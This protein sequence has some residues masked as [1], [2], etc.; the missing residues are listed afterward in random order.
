MILGG[1]LEND[2]VHTIESL[3]WLKTSF[4]SCSVFSS[5]PSELYKKEGARCNV[6]GTLQRIA[7][8]LLLSIKSGGVSWSCSGVKQVA[9]NIHSK[10]SQW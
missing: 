6:E 9:S 7:S 3:K 2:M 8:I 4:D 10:L 1:V 5:L